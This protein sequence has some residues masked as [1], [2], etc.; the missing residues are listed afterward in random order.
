ME[1]EPISTIEQVKELVSEKKYKEREA[2]I[3]AAMFEFPHD[4]VPHNLMGLMLESMDLLQRLC[5]RRRHWQ[6]HKTPRGFFP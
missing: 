3:S 4:A 1:T 6:A 2:L 5:N